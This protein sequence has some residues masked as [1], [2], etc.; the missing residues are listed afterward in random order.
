MPNWCHNT[1][2]IHGEYEELKKFRVACQVKDEETGNIYASFNKLFP[3]PDEL[4]ETTAGWFGDKDKQAEQTAKEISN[5]QKYGYKDWYEWALANYGTKWGAKD[6]EL[7]ELSPDETVMTGTYETAWSPADGLILKISELFPGL[8][9]SVVSTEESDAFIC[10]SIFSN[11]ELLYEDGEQPVIPA[12]IEKLNETDIDLF[13][14]KLMDWQ[15]E[16][17]D[18][19]NEKA[20]NE[21][22]KVLLSE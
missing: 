2:D 19:W 20:E 21:T 16:Y 12:E 10:F 6:V 14:E 8:V 7:S 3:I 17:F 5:I 13:Y 22:Q 15:T 11:G 1:M 4:A 9:F 18:L